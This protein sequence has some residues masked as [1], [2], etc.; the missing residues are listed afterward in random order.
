MKKKDRLMELIKVALMGFV[1]NKIKQ[2]FEGLK[3]KIRLINKIINITKI[4]H[5][6]SKKVGIAITFRERQLQWI[7]KTLNQY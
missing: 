7:T 6:K 5:E 3:V 1:L 4:R 2:I